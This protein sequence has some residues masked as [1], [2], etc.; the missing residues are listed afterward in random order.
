MSSPVT[1]PVR[2]DCSLRAVNTVELCQKFFTQLAEDTLL[3]SVLH[4]M[5]P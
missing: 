4:V 3:E 2:I 5:A 1:L